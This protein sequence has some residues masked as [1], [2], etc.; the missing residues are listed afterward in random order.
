METR[1]PD[2]A[3]TAEDGNAVVLREHFNGVARTLDD[4]RANE[5]ARERPARKVADVERGF[6][7]LP[8]APVAVAPH[9]D[10]EQVERML[11]GPAVDDL[12]R[13]HDQS[14]AGRERGQPI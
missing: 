1:E 5:D 10:V 2:R 4:R 11:I 7:R 3:L 14:R 9:G 13:A 8:L 12:V 6:E